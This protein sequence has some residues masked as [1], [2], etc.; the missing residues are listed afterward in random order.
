MRLAHECV[1]VAQMVPTM[2]RR[3][4]LRCYA[5]GKPATG[6]E[7][8]PPQCFFPDDLRENLLTVP[9][10][11]VH[12]NRNSKDVEYVRNVLICAAELG[13]ES[14]TVFDK[15]LRSFSRSES[16]FKRTFDSLKPVHFRGYE[17]GAFQVDQARFRKVMA[18][19]A[20]ALHF[21][22]IA[23]RRR[24]W[25]VFS[26]SL[27]NQASL[28]GIPDDWSRLRRRIADF[29]FQYIDTPQQAVFTYG[30]VEAGTWAVV[31]QL[32]FYDAIVVNVWSSNSVDRLAV[33]V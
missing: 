11:E 31:Y 9:S 24:S 16:L 14:K 10:C 18:S 7:H 29:R 21:H 12:N 3:A 4:I 2:A 1:A 27:H 30:R 15:A 13:P 20:S 8:V 5:C 32:I 19:I 25:R 26:P 22:D 33:K 23:S 6:R 28:A 17:T